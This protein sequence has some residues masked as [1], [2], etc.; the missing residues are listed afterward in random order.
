MAK[1]EGVVSVDID[2]QRQ[3]QCRQRPE[4]GRQRAALRQQRPRPELPELCP[5]GRSETQLRT[6]GFEG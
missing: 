3:A 5:A 6:G 1:P 2:V 4:R